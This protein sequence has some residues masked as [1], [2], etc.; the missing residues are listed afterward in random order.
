MCA[1]LHEAFE[2]FSHVME[3]SDRLLDIRRTLLI[4]WWHGF[5]ATEA[6]RR[7]GKTCQRPG[8]APHYTSMSR[9]H[10]MEAIICTSATEVVF[11]CG[12]RCTR[13][14]FLVSV[15]TP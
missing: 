15:R 11:R 6:T 1:V 9:M 14:L 12:G 8:D 2:T 7:Q 5:V 10:M 3:R 4:Q 13:T